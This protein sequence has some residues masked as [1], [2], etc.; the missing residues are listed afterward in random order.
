METQVE[1][2]ETLPPPIT[3]HV[4]EKESEQGAKEHEKK[5]KKEHEKEEKEEKEHEKKEKKEHEKE[6]KEKEKQHRRSLGEPEPS[7]STF[8]NDVVEMEE[9]PE[10]ERREEEE[11]KN[12][13]KRKIRLIKDIFIHII[14]VSMGALMIY[15]IVLI[16]T[17]FVDSKSLPTSTVTYSTNATLL[18]PA[19]TICNWNQVLGP[20]FDY[21]N[22]TLVDCFNWFLNTSC[23]SEFSYVVVITT[24]GN[25]SCYVFNNDTSNIYNSSQTGFGG[26]FS[27]LFSITTPPSTYLY[28]TGLQATFDAVGVVP[29]VYN[30]IRFAPPG[31]DSF[32]GI[33]VVATTFNNVTNSSDQG[34]FFTYNTLYS[35]TTLSNQPS[36]SS[37]LYVSVSFAFQTLNLQD[38]SYDSTYKLTNLFGDF[39]GMVGVLMGIDVIKLSASIPVMIL[40]CRKRKLSYVTEHFTG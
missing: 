30:E 33:Q 35:A 16:I 4:D 36:N 5:E 20:Y 34:P 2:R 38:I 29:D 19:V 7:F 25:F 31:Y 32:Y 15:Y 1:M 10:K 40:A 26:S 21:E 22:I 17:P 6:E 8:I 23:V 37:E 28:R 3:V 27:V 14:W 12:P 11:D 18:F 39:S 9:E 24:F 13:R